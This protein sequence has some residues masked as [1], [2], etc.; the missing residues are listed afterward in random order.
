MPTNDLHYL[1]IS[2]AASLIESRQL[3]PVELV[4]AHLERIEQ[5]DGRL[6]SFI[7][8]LANGATAAAA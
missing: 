5:T 6:N 2:E 7:T 4:A 8:L 1:T 3:S